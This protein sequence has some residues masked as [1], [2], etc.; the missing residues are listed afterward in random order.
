MSPE[1]STWEACMST[2]DELEREVAYLK[3]KVL[4]LIATRAMDLQERNPR[5][6]IRQASSI[7]LRSAVEDAILTQDEAADLAGLHIRQ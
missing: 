7:I 1:L 5:L 4:E 2:R 3:Q 6:S